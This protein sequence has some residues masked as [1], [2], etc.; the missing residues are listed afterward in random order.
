MALL[1]VRGISK[2]F[3][4]EPVVHDVSFDVAEGE[5][6]CL[7][8]PSGCGKTTLLRIIAGLEEPDNG[9]VT[10]DDRSLT[11]VAVHQR[12]F[13]L[14]F[15]DFALFPHKDVAANVAFGLRMQALPAQQ[16]KS[17]VTEMLEMVG[18]AGYEDRRVYELSGGEQQ[19]VALARSLAPGPR[20]LMLDEPL[21][22]LD[23]A[24]RE[25]LMNELQSILRAIGLTAIYVTHDQQ[26]AFAVADRVFIMKQGRI[27]QQGTP[28]QVYCS[29]NSLWVARFLGLTNLIPGR[30]VALDPPRVETPLGTLPLPSGQGLSA[31]QPVTVLIRPEAAQLSTEDSGGDAFHFTGTVGERSFRG[32]HYRLVIE[33]PAGLTLSFLLVP[34]EKQIPLPGEPIALDLRPSAMHPLTGE[35]DV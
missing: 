6:I 16:I 13:G 21:G 1:S 24:R 34:A 11:G 2:A 9:H 14:M 12:G 3:A 10:F 4:G 22:S 27:V 32:T 20:L 17:R 8:G 15:Q 28:Q 35:S 29:P 25:G 7:L 19:R 31:G 33:H 18:L 23:R 30:I 26:E 5:I